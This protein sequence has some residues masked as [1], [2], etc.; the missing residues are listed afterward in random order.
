MNIKENKDFLLQNP[1]QLASAEVILEDRTNVFCNVN[2][3]N[4]GNLLQR[5]VRTDRVRECIFKASGDKFWKF[6]PSAPIMAAPLWALCTCIYQSAQTNLDA[7]LYVYNI[8]LYDHLFIKKVFMTNYH[9]MPTRECIY[10]IMAMQ[11]LP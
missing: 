5:N 4:L 1:R 9:W 2:L 11:L 10:K 8:Y 3:N 6:F 7:S